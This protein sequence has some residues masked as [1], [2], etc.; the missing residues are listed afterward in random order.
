M[1]D[2]SGLV[3]LTLLREWIAEQVSICEDVL[4]LDLVYKMLLN[5]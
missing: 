4:L 5:G 1:E 2:E 3:L